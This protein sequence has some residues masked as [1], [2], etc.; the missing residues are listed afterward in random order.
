MLFR[1]IVG[2]ALR[3][4]VSEDG[5]AAQIYL[6]A[7]P[8]LLDFAERLYTEA[9]EGIRDRRCQQCGEWPCECPCPG[10][11]KHPCECHQSLFEMREP[12]LLAIDATPILDGGH[13]G[14]DHVP[15]R[16]VG[17]AIRITQE[18]D[19]H[20]HFNH[21]QLGYA[22]QRFEQMKKDAQ[23]QPAAAPLQT[24]PG[25]E[26]EK[27]RRRINRHVRQLAFHVHQKDYAKAYHE[28]IEGPFSVKF[29]EIINTWSVDKLRQ[30]ADR[31]ERRIVEVF[32]RG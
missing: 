11:G 13:V 10:C 24:N 18:S 8:V 23:P 28:E 16:F 1:Q 26:R 4:H 30:V 3:L 5:T 27:L 2:R 6:P 25:A 19:A 15:E 21:T 20:R 22:L 14:A 29:T 31:L 9:Q 12:V 7:F 17:Y 32:R